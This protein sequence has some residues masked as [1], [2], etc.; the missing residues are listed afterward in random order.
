[1]VVTLPVSRVTPTGWIG[2]VTACRWQTG[3]RLQR[4]WLDPAAVDTSVPV[5]QRHLGARQTASIQ[6]GHP[7]WVSVA[8]RVPRPITCRA[9]AP[10]RH[11]VMI[12]PSLTLPAEFANGN[13]T[14]TDFAP[15]VN[16]IFPC[17]DSPPA[18]S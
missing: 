4:R 16:A 10:L 13:T 11:R 2:L 17:P 8:A 7:V 5:P 6:D 15:S 14:L 9:I 12:V 3:R 18:V 1:M